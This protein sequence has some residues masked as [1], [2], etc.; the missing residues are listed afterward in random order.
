MAGMAERIILIPDD[1]MPEGVKAEMRAK[2]EGGGAC[3]WCGG[4][5][6]RECP[7]VK[8]IIFNPAD[9]RQVRE[10]EFWNDAEYDHSSVLWPEDCV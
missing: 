10:V 5:H 8:K 1:G 2:F 4:L 6:Q 7:R 9:D 3:R